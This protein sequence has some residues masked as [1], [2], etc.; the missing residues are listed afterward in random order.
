VYFKKCAAGASRLMQLCLVAT[1]LKMLTRT[2]LVCVIHCTYF[3][4]EMAVGAVDAAEG[5]K[6]CSVRLPM[7]CVG[8]DRPCCSITI[9]AAAV[10]IAGPGS[11]HTATSL[12]QV[13]AIGIT[14]MRFFEGLL[15]CD[16][17]YFVQ[18]SRHTLMPLIDVYHRSALIL[19]L[20]R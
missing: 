10:G 6:Y 1:V 14:A 17:A 15:C 18:Q 7:V 13:R 8:Y 5:C 19:L 2:L 4:R 20:L 3:S 9:D 16:F 12:R 11:K